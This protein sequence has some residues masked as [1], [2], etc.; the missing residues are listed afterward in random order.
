MYELTV[1]SGAVRKSL[2]TRIAANGA[3]NLD[4]VLDGPMSAGD[5]VA[6]GSF[7]LMQLY[8]NPFNSSLNISVGV[9]STGMASI[10][11]YDAAGRFQTTLFNGTLEPGIRTFRLDGASLATGLYMIGFVSGEGRFL[12]TAYLV[13]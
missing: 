6:P 7:A 13:R 8:P 11:I 2:V 1:Q 12:Q 9:R 10:N 5:P 3:T 4:V